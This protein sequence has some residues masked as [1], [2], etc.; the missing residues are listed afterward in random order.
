[1]IFTKKIEIMKKL[2]FDAKY[3]EAEFEKQHL[4]VLRWAVVSVTHDTFVLEASIYE[5]NN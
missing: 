2:P 1:M 4:N 3:V 5:T